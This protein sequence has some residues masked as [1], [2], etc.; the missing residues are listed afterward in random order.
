MRRKPPVRLVF[1]VE[2]KVLV[3]EGFFVCFFTVLTL[4]QQNPVFWGGFLVFS[5]CSVKQQQEHLLAGL[6]WL[7]SLNQHS[8]IHVLSSL[9]IMKKI[10]E[11]FT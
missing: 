7:R 1:I 11:T 9:L 8:H 3:C 2:N 5:L 4:H 6:T 10:I